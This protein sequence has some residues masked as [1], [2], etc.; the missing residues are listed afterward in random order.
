M[1]GNPV[2]EITDQEGRIC[3]TII[4]TAE[5]LQITSNWLAGAIFFEDAHP[6]QADIFSIRRWRELHR[7][8]CEHP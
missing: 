3:G 6:R 5:G 7:A 2:V 8:R 4:A 1:E